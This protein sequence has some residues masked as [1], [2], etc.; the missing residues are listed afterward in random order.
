MTHA[1]NVSIDISPDAGFDITSIMDNGVS[2]P[3]VN[4]FVISNVTGTHAVVVTF[5]E[6][7]SSPPFDAFSTNEGLL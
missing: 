6:N 1:G 5:G 2:Q 4:P 3:I 7:Q